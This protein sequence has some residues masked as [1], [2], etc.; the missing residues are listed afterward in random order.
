MS[1]RWVLD[2]YPVLHSTPGA[3]KNEWV[4]VHPNGYAQSSIPVLFGSFVLVDSDHVFFQSDV[5]GTSGQLNDCTSA[6]GITL[7]GVGKYIT[8]PG[9]NDISFMI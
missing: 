5:T 9:A 3:K 2:G 7:K 8:S 6:S 1:L 4:S